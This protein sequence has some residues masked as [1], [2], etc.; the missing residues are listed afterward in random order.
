MAAALH[1]AECDCGDRPH[2]ERET[3]ADYNQLATAAIKHARIASGDTVQAPNPLDGADD[4]PP[5]V[6]IQLKD[7]R[8]VVEVLREY[9]YDADEQHVAA[10]VRA[11]LRG[12]A[13]PDTA[14]PD[15]DPLV[16]NIGFGVT[17][18]EYVPL[19]WRQA[20]EAEEAAA[21]SLT[22]EETRDA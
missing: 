12:P 10:S 21:R 8:D 16:E 14:E 18:R 2:H 13:A 11:A 5:A 7:R 1:S 20:Q 19:S 15:L 4:L 9:G 6:R 3:G 17:N 22:T